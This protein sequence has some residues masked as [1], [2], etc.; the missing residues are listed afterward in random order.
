M[1]WK[2]SKVRKVRIEDVDPYLLSYEDE[3]AYYAQNDGQWNEWCDSKYGLKS[4]AM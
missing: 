3:D 2:S 4:A 1:S